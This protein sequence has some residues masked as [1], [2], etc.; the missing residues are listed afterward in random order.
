MIDKR[1]PMY[2]SAMKDT[3]IYE[4]PLNEVI[5]VC[6]RLEQLFQQIDHQL[7]DTSELG[8][9]NVTAF[10]INVLHLLDRPDLKAKLAKE[11]SHHHANL[12]RFDNSPEIDKEKLHHITQQLDEHARSLIDS[13]GKIGHRLRDIELLNMLRMHLASPGGGCSFDIPLYH[14]WLQQPPD[15]RMVTVNDW[16]SE[17]AQIKTVVLL[18]LDLVRKNAKVENKTAVHGFHQELL[19]PQWN[20]R[21]IRIGLAPNLPTYPEISIGRHFFSV[22]YFIPDI[23]RRAVQY[24]ENL[25]F[26]VAYCNS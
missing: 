26:W 16:L 22:R 17:F 18:I 3:I 23:E 13:S 12:M 7:S 4:Q 6:L 19:D 11:L 14:Y 25:S 15:V 24:T 9:R 20:L 21:M 10:I 8:T 1:I 2:S 5:R